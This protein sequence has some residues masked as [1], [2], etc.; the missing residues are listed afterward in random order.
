MP[1]TRMNNVSVPPIGRPRSDGYSSVAGAGALRNTS[2]G[3]ER[4][5]AKT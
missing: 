5:I 3:P 4:R 2:T 1:V